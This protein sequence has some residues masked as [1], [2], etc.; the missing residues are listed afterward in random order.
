[1]KRHVS[2]THVLENFKMATKR[3]NEMT[4]NTHIPSLPYNESPTSMGQDISLHLTYCTEESNCTK[5]SNT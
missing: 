3:Q 5:F 1:M 2:G 4:D